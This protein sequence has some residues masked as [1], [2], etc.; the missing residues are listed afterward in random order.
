V[1]VGGGVPHP[2]V[3]GRTGGR[4]TRVPGAPRSMVPLSRHHG[5][6]VVTYLSFALVTFNWTY[7]VS[8]LLNYKK[9]KN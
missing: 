4:H 5:M 8:L 7:N 3:W 9:D 1:S 2:P 6:L